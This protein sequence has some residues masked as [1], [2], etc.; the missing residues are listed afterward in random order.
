MT[1]V[2]RSCRVFSVKNDQNSRTKFFDRLKKLVLVLCSGIS[3]V[4]VLEIVKLQNT[5]FYERLI[6]PRH[7]LL[8]TEPRPLNRRFEELPSFTRANGGGWPEL[9]PQKNCS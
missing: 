6:C 5:L 9:E 8:S 1:F 2:D 4:F 7:L 3:L